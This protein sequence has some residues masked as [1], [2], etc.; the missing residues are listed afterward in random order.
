[1]FVIFGWN[2]VIEDY[3]GPIG[4]RQC[5]NCGNECLW[6]L[7]KRR[8]CVTLFFV[9]VIP[10]EKHWVLSCRI[11]KAGYHV[12]EEKAIQLK[13]IA[14]ENQKIIA[15]TPRIC[16]QCQNELRKAMCE[17]GGYGWYCHSCRQSLGSM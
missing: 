15:N 13:S 7:S 3:I 8:K 14:I 10:Y 5:P 6:D 4:L 16:P 12:E 2:K 9:P 17:D 1:M 11:C